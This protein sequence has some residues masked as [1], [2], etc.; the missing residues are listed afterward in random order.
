MPQW[1]EFDRSAVRKRYDRLARM[2]ALSDWLLCVPS[3][4]RRRAAARLELPSGGRALEIG[5]GT[6]I[7]LGFLRDA[8]GPAGQVYGVDLS[9]GMLQV[10]RE[11][12]K[13]QNWSNVTI[14][15]SDAGEYA[16]PEPLDGILFG[17]SYNTMPHH[18]AVLQHAWSMLRPGG[19]LVIMDAK[20]PPGRFGQV[21]LPF[22]IWLM[23]RTLLGNPLIKPWEHLRQI[24]GD[25]E[26]EEF[27]FSSYYICRARK[28]LGAPTQREHVAE[29]AMA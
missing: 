10:C 19:R 3:G 20:L 6:G 4:F 18:R 14:V 5:C 7:N 9:S 11:R 12:A 26:M 17:L 25:V 21:I 29:R 1:K 15:E 8:V 22:S 23:R 2:I 28:P 16:P 27:R 24:A 13:Q